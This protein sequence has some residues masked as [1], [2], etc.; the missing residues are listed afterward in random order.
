MFSILEGK[1]A[2]V[3]SLGNLFVRVTE[4]HFYTYP[5]SPYLSAVEI[6]KPPYDLRVAGFIS[7]VTSRL[8]TEPAG[9]I[10]VLLNYI[11][12]LSLSVFICTEVVIAPN[13]VAFP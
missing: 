8:S 1:G 9:M 10:A 2:T 6:S 7:S 13:G 11:V 3:S 5:F 12:I 4:V